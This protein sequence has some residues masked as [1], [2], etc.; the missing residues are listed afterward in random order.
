[1]SVSTLFDRLSTSRLYVTP[2]RFFLPLDDPFV[3]RGHL[4]AGKLFESIRIRNGLDIHPWP[5]PAIESASQERSCN[6][7]SAKHRS[8][9]QCRG[10]RCT[11][12]QRFGPQQTGTQQT[13]DCCTREPASLDTCRHCGEYWQCFWQCFARHVARRFHERSVSIFTGI[14]ANAG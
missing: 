14:T 9:F 3:V 11:C 10:L 1:M 6:A 13:G 12:G 7:R 8:I 5:D 2:S 4:S